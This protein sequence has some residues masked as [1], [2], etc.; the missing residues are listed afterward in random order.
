MLIHNE[1]SLNS[2]SPSFLDGRGHLRA[3]CPDS[4]CPPFLVPLGPK[5]YWTRR[6]LRLSHVSEYGKVIFLSGSGAYKYRWPSGKVGAR[7]TTL[8]PAQWKICIELLTPPKLMVF[9]QCLVSIKLFSRQEL[10]W[11]CVRVCVPL[12]RKLFSLCL[13][14]CLTFMSH[15]SGKCNLFREVS[16]GPKC[17][18]NK[19]TERSFCYNSTL[20]LCFHICYL[21]MIGHSSRLLTVNPLA[22]A[23]TSLVR[24]C[25]LVPRTIP[26]TW[27]FSSTM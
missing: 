3:S 26:H 27:H 1:S 5:Y 15:V 25:P 11:V 17:K 9:F 20:N 22:M 24:H 8:H 13:S 12:L 16:S 18:S 19:H 23:A 6:L 10:T 14:E 7:G 21:T 4:Q 2:Y